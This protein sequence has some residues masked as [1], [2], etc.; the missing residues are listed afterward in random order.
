M[1]STRRRIVLK[2][3]ATAVD[4]WVAEGHAFGA[5]GSGVIFCCCEK[6]MRIVEGAGTFPAFTRTRTF[7]GAVSYL[8]GS[9]AK[10]EII[11]I[12]SLQDAA[13]LGSQRWPFMAFH[14]ALQW[15]DRTPIRLLL[16]HLSPTI[17]ARTTLI[18]VGT[19]LGSLLD[20]KDKADEKPKEIDWMA[21]TRAISNG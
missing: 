8:T 21:I 12:R 19:E 10:L 15:P 4:K 11:P 2:D 1:N 20:D 14:N 17:G 7:S 13:H 16:P 3:P 18:S 5:L 6:D 9:R